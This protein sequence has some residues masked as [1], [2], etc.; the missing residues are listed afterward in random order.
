MNYYQVAAKWWAD[1]LYYENSEGE[2]RG[3]LKNPQKVKIFTDYL[4]MSIKMKVEDYSYGLRKVNI[5]TFDGF[6]ENEL[7]AGA[8]KTANIKGVNVPKNVLMSI[9]KDKVKVERHEILYSET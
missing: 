8:L 7:L 9:C 5:I 3:D 4:A 2:M 6:S 1:N